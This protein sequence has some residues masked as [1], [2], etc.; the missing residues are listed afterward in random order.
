MRDPKIQALLDALEKIR[1]P[2]KRDHK[3]PDTYT[4]LGC[5]MT[6]ADEAIKSF[7][8]EEAMG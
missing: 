1:D 3:E 7:E 6:I 2:R 5:V 8:R 4:E